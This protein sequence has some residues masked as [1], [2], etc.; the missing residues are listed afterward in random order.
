MSLRPGPTRM[1]PGPTRMLLC[2]VLLAGPQRS[3]RGAATKGSSPTEDARSD[4][5]TRRACGST[6]SKARALLLVLP[7][8]SK[9]RVMAVHGVKPDSLYSHHR[10]RALLGSA[11]STA[12][13]RGESQRERAREGEGG[14]GREGEDRGRERV[15]ER[16]RAREREA[17]STAPYRPREAP[18]RTARHLKSPASSARDPSLTRAAPSTA[19]TRG[20]VLDRFRLARTRPEPQKKTSVRTHWRARTAR[21]HAF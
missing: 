21:T 12:L 17:T 20:A 16:E 19:D 8:S 7:S 6:R 5:R 11:P 4:C 1:S 13:D 10:L 18:S 15:R 9:A 3:A 2:L 14:R